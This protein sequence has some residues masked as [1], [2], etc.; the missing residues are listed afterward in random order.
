[1]KKFTVIFLIVSIFFAHNSIFAS[2]GGVLLESEILFMKGKYNQAQKNLQG[3]LN[4]TGRLE[5][6]KVL[7]L[8][9][10]CLIKMSQHTKARKYL[11]ELI[12]EYPSSGLCDDATL[13]FGDS[14]Y[15]ESN[16]E[17]ALGLY[18][19]MSEKYPSSTLLS[20]AIYK[21]G[22]SCMKLGRWQE[23]RFYFQKVQRS[24]PLSFEAKKVT[25]SLNADEFYFTVQVGSFRKHSN[26]STLCNRLKN[27]NFDS[28]LKKSKEGQDIYYR[29]RVGKFNTLYQAKV[30]KR[31]LREQGLPTKIYP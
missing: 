24:F 4:R 20:I 5:R 13:A 10:L 31:Q 14:Y 19:S 15:S 9:S 30:C 22:K 21:S 6:P 1:M 26:A 28:Y 17:T 11:Q 29:V 12:S 3:L 2:S 27:K 25:Q 7:F 23:A 8:N 18:R 16:F